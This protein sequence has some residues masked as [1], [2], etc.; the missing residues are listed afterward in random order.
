M[1]LRVTDNLCEQVIFTFEYHINRPDISNWATPHKSERLAWHKRRRLKLHKIW[2]MFQTFLTI[3]SFQSHFKSVS[4]LHV[5]LVALDART[6]RPFCVADNP[7]ATV[8]ELVCKRG[9][10]EQVG[11]GESCAHN[12]YAQRYAQS[13]SAAHPRP[14]WIHNCHVPEIG[15]TQFEHH[16]FLDGILYLYLIKRCFETTFNNHRY[17]WIWNCENINHCC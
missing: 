3:T 4:H 14:Q 9:K 8:W 6:I 17:Y 11:H 5:L 12:P 10:E 7:C 13:C 15:A 16:V 1:S 2:H